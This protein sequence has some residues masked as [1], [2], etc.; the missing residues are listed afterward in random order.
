MSE[1]ANETVVD[2]P[3]ALAGAETGNIHQPIHTDSHTGD[4]RN[5]IY[6]DY[7]L[8]ARDTYCYL[9]GPFDSQKEA[10]DWGAGGD[11]DDYMNGHTTVNNPDDDP[12]WQ[13]I[14]LACVKGTVAVIGVRK[15]SDGPMDRTDT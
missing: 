3:A 1:T 15:P 12:R 2:Q 14:R 7:I 6:K 11:Y 9:V 4:P 10:A 8:V 5:A 13:T